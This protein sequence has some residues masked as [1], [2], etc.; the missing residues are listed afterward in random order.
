[1]PGGRPPGGR[2]PGA[3]EERLRDVVFRHRV[4]A[5]QRVVQD[6]QPPAAGERPCQAEALGLAAGQRGRGAGCRVAV[7]QTAYEVVGAGGAGGLPDPVRGRRR[8]TEAD[9]V[10]DGLA[11][12]RGPFEGVTDR[13]PQ[14]VSV[15]FAQR[16][17][18][19]EHLA[20]VR[21][22]QPPGEAASSDLPAPERPTTASVVPPGTTR[23]TPSSTVRPPRFRAVTARSSNCPCPGG[24]RRVPYVVAGSS[25]TSP[26]RRAEARASTS[27]PSR[28]TSTPTPVASTAY[29]EAAS[30]S[31][32]ESRCWV[33]SRPGRGQHRDLQQRRHADGLCGGAPLDAPHPVA[34]AGQ[35]GQRPQDPRHLLVGG[36]AR[37]DGARAADR[38]RQRARDPPLRVLVTRHAPRGV[39]GEGPEHRH[40]AGTP[41]RNTSASRGSISQS[42]T[43]APSGAASAAK[44]PASVA[45]AV[46]AWA[47]LPTRRATSSPGPNRSAGP[48]SHA[49]ARCPV[50]RCAA[51]RWRGRSWSRPV[52]VSHASS[53]AS[54]STRAVQ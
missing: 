5:G 7:G 11:E 25:S 40:D 13:A 33:S 10:L 44:R 24:R 22:G 41:P 52:P 34:L 31:P 15:Q 53:T 37:R 28:P 27:P 30:N 32:T 48:R 54:T 42:A 47:A 6:Q 19:E 49:P 3:P 12:Q 1:M 9:R 17:P 8:V 35:F 4:E 29:R 36:P 38:L 23:S 2:I 16:H 14:R 18:V 21:V 20:G 46:P 39:A 50:S 43:T 26:S 45:G 51:T